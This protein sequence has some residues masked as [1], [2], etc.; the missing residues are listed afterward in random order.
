MS[1][2]R[3]TWEMVLDADDPADA[4]QKALQLMQDPESTATVF[5]VERVLTVAPSD[6]RPL[7]FDSCGDYDGATGERW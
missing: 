2:Y 7:A 5:T 3:V 6:G 1:E 4:A